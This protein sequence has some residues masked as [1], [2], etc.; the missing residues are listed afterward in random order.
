MTKSHDFGTWLMGA[1]V[2][3][4]LVASLAALTI[5][6]GPSQAR[7][8]RSDSHT[9]GQLVSAGQ[10]LKCYHAEKGRLPNDPAD[11]LLIL[12]SKE[13]RNTCRIGRRDNSIDRITYTRPKPD[14]ARLC[15]TFK[16]PI[17][18]NTIQNMLYGADVSYEPQMAV[19]FD[20]NKAR[21]EAGETCY[22]AIFT[23]ASSAP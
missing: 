21:P 7:D 2:T 23:L 14:T 3:T 4:A 9:L 8:E 5:V 18:A 15:A 20:F 22:E 1:L 16:R 19:L 13:N 17:K 11:A 6:G 10:M 12:T